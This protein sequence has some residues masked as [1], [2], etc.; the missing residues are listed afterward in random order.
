MQWEFFS[1]QIIVWEGDEASHRPNEQNCSAQPFCCPAREAQLLS[2]LTNRNLLRLGAWVHSPQQP[3]VS[4]LK[5]G[6]MK[7]GGKNKSPVSQEI[8]RTS[9]KGKTVRSPVTQ[10][11][12][13]RPLE[14]E[15][16]WF[17]AH[18]SGCPPQLDER[19]QRDNDRAGPCLTG[20]PTKSELQN[21]M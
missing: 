9:E 11:T 18:G 4:Y 12:W 14:L 8:L 2:S 16:M 13:R 15:G 17:G 7:D 1:L 20:P 19:V 10:S 21:T 3:L 6:L 5:Y